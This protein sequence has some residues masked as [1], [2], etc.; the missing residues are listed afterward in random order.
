MVHPQSPFVWNLRLP[1]SLSHMHDFLL[2]YRKHSSFAQMKERNTGYKKKEKNKCRLV[3]TH[4]QPLLCSCIGTD[5]QQ[6][7]HS[8]FLRWSSISP[9]C[10]GV[11]TELSEWSYWGPF[12]ALEM[13]VSIPGEG[14]RNSQ[15]TACSSQTLLS[16]LATHDFLYSL[17]RVFYILYIG[18]VFELN[19][20]FW[21]LS[22][23][24]FFILVWRFTLEYVLCCTG[25]SVETAIVSCYILA[26]T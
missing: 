11:S 2:I 26:N 14:V 9:N 8:R 13:R 12:P 1:C 20:Q 7:L 4:Q 25:D 22:F 16:S 5:S 17:Y 19:D 23:E 6:G 21:C 15:N 24:I 3:P 18:G 10:R